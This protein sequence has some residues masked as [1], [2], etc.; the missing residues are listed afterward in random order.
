MADSSQTVRPAHDHIEVYADRAATEASEVSCDSQ[1][2]IEPRGIL[3]VTIEVSAWQPDVE[4][5]EYL[6]IGQARLAEEL[7]FRDFEEPDVGAVEYDPGEIHVRPPNVLVDDEGSRGH[8]W[9]GT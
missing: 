1:T 8:R 3:E 4:P 5:L 9:G 2:V 6:A 7:G